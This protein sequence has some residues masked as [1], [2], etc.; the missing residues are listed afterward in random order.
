MRYYALTLRDNDSVFEVLLLSEE[1]TN[2]APNG[3]WELSGAAMSPKAVKWLSTS[4]YFTARVVS[5]RQVLHFK[6]T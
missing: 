2:G 1:V 5:S 6:E 4:S 3:A